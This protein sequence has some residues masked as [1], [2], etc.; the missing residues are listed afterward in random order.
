MNSSYKMIF[1]FCIFVT[2]GMGI[3]IFTSRYHSNKLQIINREMAELRSSISFDTQRLKM[4]RM[5]TLALNKD[6]KISDEKTKYEIANEIINM[7]IKYPNLSLPIILSVIEQ[8]S[9]FDPDAKSYKGALGLMQVMPVTGFFIA[10][11]ENI[12]WISSEQTLL[13]PILNIRIGCAFLSQLIG[14]YGL[15]GALIA[16]NSGERYVRLWSNN[17]FSASTLAIE[18]R[19]YVP[20]VLQKISLYQEN[21]VTLQ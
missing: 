1:L 18:T 17:N 15:N 6:N 20:A 12:P 9:K 11:E 7:T 19:T 3:L 13:N 16:Y 10:G 14:S 8:E 5:V 2:A 4:I 21:E